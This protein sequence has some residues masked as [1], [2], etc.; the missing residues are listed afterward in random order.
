MYCV[1][2]LVFPVTFG[3]TM[4]GGEV[5]KLPDNAS[6]GTSYILF[7]VALIFVFAGLGFATRVIVFA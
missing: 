1:A 3:S 4:V 5:Y 6:V 2:A 7:V